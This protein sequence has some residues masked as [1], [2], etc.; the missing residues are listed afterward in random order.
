VKPRYIGLIVGLA[1]GFILLTIGLWKAIAIALIGLVGYVVGGILGGEI[2]LQ[3]YIDAVQ[4][5]LAGLRRR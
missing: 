2:D 1:L 4:R 5:Y 3:R